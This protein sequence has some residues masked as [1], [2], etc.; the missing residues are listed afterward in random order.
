MINDIATNDIEYRAN[1]IRQRRLEAMGLSDQY[2]LWRETVP[3]LTDGEA[4]DTF[5]NAQVTEQG[6]LDGRTRAVTGGADVE[7]P[8]TPP[9]PPTDGQPEAP[10]G[11]GEVSEGDTEDPPDLKLVPGMWVP[12]EESQ[13]INYEAPPTS[14]FTL[15][16][17]QEWMDN[18]RKV[19]E[20]AGSPQTGIPVTPG[21]GEFTPEPD[22]MNDE[23]IARWAK[24]Q[25]SLFNWNIAS[26]MDWGH[27]ITSQDDPQ[28]ALAFLNLINM[29]DHSDGG[30]A[31]F[32]RALGGIMTDPTTYL[33]V[34]VGSV[35]AK[36]TARALAKKQI[37]NLV[38]GMIIG[39]T[40]GGI[41]G[42]V[43]AGGFDLVTQNIEQEAGAREDL[44]LGRAAISTG[45]GIGLGA[46]LAGTG[47]A[48]I[49]RQMDK[50]AAGAEA[51]MTRLLG[52]ATAEERRIAENLDARQ[53]IEMIK[54]NARRD[55]AENE[56]DQ[57]AAVVLRY[58]ENR[59]KLPRHSDGT[60]NIGKVAA[61]LD[62]LQGTAKAAEIL[63]AGD[64]AMEAPGDYDLE[65]T[66][67]GDKPE[68][69]IQ[70]GTV[71]K[72]LEDVTQVDEALSESEDITTM[73][74][75][76]MKKAGI[77]DYE[78]TSL[79]P[80]LLG[81]EGGVTIEGRAER[82]AIRFASEED[83]AKF[84]E[85]YGPRATPEDPSLTLR[86]REDAAG[87]KPLPSEESMLFAQRIAEMHE[88]GAKAEPI[89]RT[90]TMPGSRVRGIDDGFQ[91]EVMGRTKNGWYLLRNRQ[92]GEE[93]NRRKGQ[94]TI[95]E[96]QPAP[97]TAGPMNLDPFTTSA[98][99]IM[100]MN[101]SVVSGTLKRVE[102]TVAEQKAI[103]N[104][105]QKMGI[106]ITEKN[107]ATHWTPAELMFLRDTYNAQAN[108]M[109]GLARQLKS[110]LDANGRLTNEE[111]ARFNQAHTQF[112][113]TRD[114]FFGV[115]GNAARQLQIL[116]TRPT[117]EVYDFGQSLLDSISIQGGR[118]NTERAITLMADFAGGP[119]RGPG[120]RNPVK[121]VSGISDKIWGTQW[122][123]AVLN[124]RYN[125]MLSSWRTHFFNFTGNSLSGVWQHLVISPFRMGINN[126]NYAY[127][128]ARS[129][130]QPSFRPDPADRMTR[131]QYYA[132]LRGHYE[133][134]RDSI[135]LAKEIAMGRDIGEGKVWNELGL[136]YN[137]IN[138][139]QSIPGK[140]GTTPVRLLEAGDA[141][142]KN[143]AYQ[144]KIH[145]LASIK[146]RYEQI[147][148]GGNYQTRYRRWV[149]D[150]DAPM[151]REAQAFGQKQTYTNDPNVYGG[152]LAALAKG[153]SEAQNRS[154]AV[155]M[156]VPFVRTPAN[157]LS[158]SMEMI[159]ANTVLSPSKTYNAIM[160][161]GVTQRQSQEAQARLMA[162][163]G[164]W[165]AAYELYQNGDLTGTGPSSWEERKVWEAAGWQDN[166][167]KIWGS[168]V[169]ISRMA[170][171]GQSLATIASVF[172]F[173]AMT[174]QQEK[175]V[176][177][178][179]GAGLLYT[180]DMIIDE[181]YLSTATDLLTAISSKEESRARSVGAS[182][183]NSILV[184][185]LMRDIRRP[186]DEQM[187]ATTSPNLL[188]QVQ[189]QMMNASPWHSELLPP[190][191]D[192]RGDAKNYW[193]NAYLRAVIPFNIR[194]PED[195]DPASAA[196]AYARVP[197]NTPDRA[198]TIPGTSD[199]IDL[200]AMDN[201]AGFVYDKY[202]QFV[203][204]RRAQAVDT[205]I[206]SPFYRGAVEDNQM[207]PGSNAEIGLREAL[208]IGTKAG[209][210]EML[211]FLIQ[212][213]G[214]NSTFDRGNGQ[215][216]EIQHQVSVQE[217]IRLRGIL[218]NEDAVDPT[219]EEQL[220]FVID[221]PVEGPQFFSP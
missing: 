149:D 86:Q 42:G 14:S 134:F 48:L 180:A 201:G 123:A 5:V 96:L 159:G 151:Q 172:D 177:A 133:G 68:A 147:H 34:G 11:P 208:A 188:Q 111:M 178:W 142:F 32:G 105:L 169:D 21:Y 20:F 168:W 135:F 66:P 22:E 148:E 33:G 186:A 112:V 4:Y 193:G 129:T 6:A 38:K 119:P 157:L 72:D 84:K 54:T 200:L 81:G 52:G 92:T 150:P 170:P 203:G 167:A 145:E 174:Q 209:R 117:D 160:G 179:I 53:L 25:M 3:E 221:Q 106:N 88:A 83:A 104:E 156:I 214:E 50:L 9:T 29:Y 46:L 10:G 35:A 77:E 17:N 166:S 127:Q 108:G 101:E 184:P 138:V 187:R 31:E 132:E 181:S 120:G 210:E 89:P 122:K 36:G 41:E 153:V 65:W 215:I 195:S 61:E 182:M 192:W 205:V 165:L 144:S 70:H 220:P 126:A 121:D 74:E 202:L 91:Y 47:G 64:E 110:N 139:P 16:S 146:A 44:N 191:R 199:S 162:A 28:V 198:I 163:A 219:A 100:A 51:E 76:F 130:I 109:A 173:Y 87:P 93:V 99:R 158:Y 197:V 212:H 143:Q 207:G 80:D 56:R 55:L 183:I 24:E 217:Y 113:A 60:I 131:H 73:I 185:N 15:P 2:G 115:S 26:T 62:E 90:A 67:E 45:A 40:A 8:T 1:Q 107:L 63:E 196:L 136:R 124:A 79:D 43:I 128:M 141:F 82:T 98:A 97:D 102:I 49:G 19:W 206:E 211:N 30:P 78:I 94:F 39:G 204:Q 85:A 189:K 164:L 216:I 71:V 137:V 75:H 12:P 27:K 161:R 213:S 176:P 57:T 152:V 18:A 23:A 194:N 118:A 125:L 37:S 140:M 175:D 7:P 171:A 69:I 116:R 154:M 58:L 103:V 13:A 218:R 95:E 59:D 155:N 190:Q 114:L